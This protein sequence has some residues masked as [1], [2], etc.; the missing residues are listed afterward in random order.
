MTSC[1]HASVETVGGGNVRC[2]NPRCREVMAY[3][4]L[5]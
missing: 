4:S 2:R 1:R 3:D 5:R